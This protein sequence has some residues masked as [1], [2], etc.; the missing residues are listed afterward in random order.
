MSLMNFQNANIVLVIIIIIAFN[1]YLKQTL[2]WKCNQASNQRKY[3]Y[4]QASE[5]V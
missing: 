4:Y 1:M 3:V 2:Y 5:I